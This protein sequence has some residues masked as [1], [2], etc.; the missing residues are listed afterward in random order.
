VGIYLPTTDALD[1]IRLLDRAAAE[2]Y[3]RSDSFDESSAAH[4]CEDMSRR[5]LTS[6]PRNAREH[7]GRAQ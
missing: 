3:Y 1:I 7:P 5:L 6:L 2:I 4:D